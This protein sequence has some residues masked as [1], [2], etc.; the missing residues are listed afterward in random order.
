MMIDCLRPLMTRWFLNPI[1][2]L[3]SG[4][5]PPTP[6]PPSP[7]HTWLFIADATNVAQRVL[8]SW[9]T[10]SLMPIIQSCVVPVRPLTF[11]FFIQET[12]LILYITS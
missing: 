11:F 5:K 7:R 10:V 12:H 3:E 1:T 9:K 2:A 6:P 8:A 4:I